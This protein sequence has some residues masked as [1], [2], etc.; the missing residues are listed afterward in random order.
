MQLNFKQYSSQGPA[1]IILHGLFGSLNN[2]GWHSKEL[3]T[4]FAVYGLDLRNH[5]ASPHSDE[6]SYQAM[7]ADVLE[8]MDQQ[9]IAHAAVIGHSMGGKVAMQLALTAADRIDRLLV[10]DIA[11][12]NYPANSGGH[13]EVFAGMESIDLATLRSRS[14][15]DSQ[16]VKFVEEAGVRQ[17]LLTNLIKNENSGYHWRLNLSALKAGYGD[18]RTMPENNKPFTKD[19]L[20]V[21]GELSNY[22]IEANQAEIARLFPNAKVKLIMGA[23]H[24]LHAE[25]PQLFNKIA[26]NFLSEK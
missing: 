7:A 16:L 20:F 5:G 2:W 10:V 19:T 25:K 3:A 6:M 23:G 18:L 13:Q 8:F 12:V 14:E 11:P 9:Q 1:L 4:G 22:I 17:F 24:W 26:L 21:K 15:A